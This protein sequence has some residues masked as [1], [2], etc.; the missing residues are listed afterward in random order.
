MRFWIVYIIQIL[1][2]KTATRK[3]RSGPKEGKVCG[4]DFN[5]DI[6]ILI[7]SSEETEIKDNYEEQ[8]R[9]TKKLIQWMPNVGSV[10]KVKVIPYSYYLFKE[11]KPFTANLTSEQH[12]SLINR[13]TYNKR[14]GQRIPV[15]KIIQKTRKSI[16]GEDSQK[17]KKIMIL[18]S[19]EKSDLNGK[20]VAQSLWKGYPAD[21]IPFTIVLAVGQDENDM[22][23]LLQIAE[24]PCYVI[25]IPNWKSLSTSLSILK[26]RICEILKND[27]N[28]PSEQ[29]ASRKRPKI[30]DFDSNQIYNSD[31][32]GLPICYSDF[33]L[34]LSYHAGRKMKNEAKHILQAQR[35]FIKQLFQG[36][37]N[38]GDTVT[39]LYLR[40]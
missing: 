40:I 34:F 21:E 26:Q 19:A 23:S 33:N 32:I 29:E 27:S 38:Y 9:I 15:S 3:I 13:I 39:T 6:A 8:K 28:S 4:S 24:N 2:A 7:D 25:P 20:L 37:T 1:E 14:K 36:F 11:Q 17:M 22:K 31:S 5:A 10:N 35:S 30:S 12:E 18:I 16:F